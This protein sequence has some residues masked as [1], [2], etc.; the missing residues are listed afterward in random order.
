M[1]DLLASYLFSISGC[2]WERCALEAWPPLLLYR[3]ALQPQRLNIVRGVLGS[4]L[5]ITLRTAMSIAIAVI[6]ALWS[7]IQPLVVLA[8]G[9]GWCEPCISKLPSASSFLEASSFQ[10]CSLQ[11]VSWKL[12]PAEQGRGSRG[13]LPA[14]CMGRGRAEACCQH[15][16]W[17]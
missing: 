3:C 13:M 11:A 17:V 7:Y 14:W 16:A 12:S 1:G 10:S 15:G 5:A 4:P 6:I 8:L 9:W 2:T